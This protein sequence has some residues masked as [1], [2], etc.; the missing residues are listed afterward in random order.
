MATGLKE[1]R[2]SKGWSQAQL[3]DAISKHLNQPIRQSHISSWESGVEPGA[4]VG[5]AIRKLSRGAVKWGA[6]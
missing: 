1:W 3:A 2:E 6:S 5:E 4:G